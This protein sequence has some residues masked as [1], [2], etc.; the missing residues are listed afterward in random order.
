LIEGISFLI[1]IVNNLI[2]NN[3][4]KIWQFVNY[5]YLYYVRGPQLTKTTNPSYKNK[6]KDLIYHFPNANEKLIQ[7]YNMLS[8]AGFDLVVEDGQ[9]NVWYSESEIKMDMEEGLVIVPD[10]YS[11]EF[12]ERQD[13]LASQW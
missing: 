9:L 3:T 8:E 10:E 7:A 5:S 1:K 12:Q 11:E 2:E 4:T 6:M 13:E